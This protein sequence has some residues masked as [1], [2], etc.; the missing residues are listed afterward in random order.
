MSPKTKLVIGLVTVL[1]AGGLGWVAGQSI[2]SP[3]EAASR[4]APPD[5][6]PITVEVEQRALSTELILRGNVGYSAPYDVAVAASSG[7][8]ESSASYV[9]RTPEIGASVAE[10]SSILE[11][12]GRP[13][14]ALIGNIPMY[15][16]LK[17]GTT[18]DDVRELEVA[19]E[20]LGYGPGPVDGKFDASTASAVN[21]LY[22]GAGASTPVPSEAIRKQ[23][24]DA[25]AAVTSAEAQVRQASRSSTQTPEQS[26]ILQAQGTVRS[27]Q[28]AA[29]KARTDATTALAQANDAINDAT[30]ARDEAQRLLTKL[31]TRL[32]TAK[33][34]V[35]PDTG[36]SPSTPEETTALQVMI[37]ELTDSSAQAT[38]TYDKAVREVT[39]VV[40]QLPVV[41]RDNDVTIQTAD[42]A[43]QVAQQQLNEL[44]NPK[45]DTSQKASIEAAQL[46]LTQAKK[47][48]E[49]ISADAGVTVPASEIAFVPTLPGRIDATKAVIGKAPEN[50][51]V[52]ISGSKLAVESSVRTTDR[53]YIE[54]GTKATVE[55]SDRDLTVTG[56]VETIDNKPGTHEVGASN[57]WI[58][59]KLDEIPE[60][61]AG[62]SVK[63]TIPVS[64]TKGEVLAVPL[65][66]LSID[67]GGNP[68]VQVLSKN[69]KKTFVPVTIG[70]VAQ[71]FAEVTG[72][73]G[74][75]L[76]KGD[77]VIVGTA[78]AKDI[79]EKLDAQ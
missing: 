48:L 72:R 54:I 59:V 7:G 41:Q 31:Q 71:G 74:T 9:T 75:T 32:A 10:G 79:A 12:S 33:G 34:G 6:S 65:A 70:L 39:R 62:S 53:K 56:S 78:G 30:A 55:A 1:A 77:L 47:T 49:E 22:V 24:R 25:Q 58:S 37:N 67:G 52:T 21:R 16:N 66:A 50:P 3:D 4:A 63:L 44:L 15:R 2:E 8:G 18:G 17:I 36:V 38:I 51:L 64:A 43:V 42:T 35:H 45:S 68:R 46:T 57:I 60:G 5:A 27:A 61:L 28:A 11:I 14:I 20:R 26:A 76:R 40:S 23:L 29:A 13:L 69:K 19:L 73:S